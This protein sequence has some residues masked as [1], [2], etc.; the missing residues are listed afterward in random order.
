M[1]EVL[2]FIFQ[3][4]THWLGGLVI[5]CVITSAITSLIALLTYRRG[6]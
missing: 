5:L 2:Q 3:D 4:F 1:L 6:E